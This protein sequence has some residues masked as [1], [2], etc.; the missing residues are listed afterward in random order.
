MTEQ[1]LQSIKHAYLEYKR[2]LILNKR[3]NPTAIEIQLPT[4]KSFHV[5]QACSVLTLKTC[6]R[7]A[8]QTAKPQ[9]WK[10]IFRKYKFILNET[11]TIPM[12]ENSY[13]LTFSSK[14]KVHQLS[15]RPN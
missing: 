1:K 9:N 2:D 8:M 10:F 7:K 3:F 6:Y 13:I 5:P 4:G 15:L 12:Q 14:V 11:F